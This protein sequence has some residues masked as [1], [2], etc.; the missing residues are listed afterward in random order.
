MV[1]ET[2]TPSQP[3][4][5]TSTAPPMEDHVATQTHVSSPIMDNIKEAL[6]K[7]KPAEEK[8]KEPEA[9][10]ETSDIENTGNP[11]IEPM[12]AKEEALAKEEEVPAKEEEAKKTEPLVEAEAGAEVTETEKETKKYEPN[13]KF[14]ASQK[15]YEIDEVLR[16]ALVSQEAEDTLKKLYEKAYGLDA[17]MEK[18]ATLSTNLDDSNTKYAN[19]E[20]SI[21]DLQEDYKRGNLD[22]FFEK[23]QI[24][25]DKIY[26]WV[27]GK[28][29]Y[30][31][32]EPEE[33]R[34]IDQQR[35]LS[36]NAYQSDRR[37]Q[38]S[39]D[40]LSQNDVTSL[41][42]EMNIVF[43][44]DNVKA[45]ET[46]FDQKMGQGAFRNEVVRHGDDAWVSQAQKLSGLQA[47]MGV[48]EKFKPFLDV[49]PQQA[50][51]QA[52]ATEQTGQTSPT[53]VSPQ[54][55]TTPVIPVVAGAAARS[56]AQG[57]YTSIDQIRKLYKERS[58]S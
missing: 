57:G 30:E 35:Q 42:D 18:N 36:E 9:I 40:R 25:K 15:E 43:S 14:Q 29:Q 12:A 47:T 4:S 50:T 26:E 17:T 44:L 3:S 39:E 45:F 32:A 5:N 8:S 33:R 53:V 56:P 51:P 54:K 10:E 48:I 13:Y 1:T 49:A 27:Y 41:R 38:A 34:Q 28:V 16:P 55:N 7:T 21:L 58:E 19:I 37:A 23:L 2:Q 46:S 20:G 22:A 52:N 24:P 6:E 11:V 31:Q